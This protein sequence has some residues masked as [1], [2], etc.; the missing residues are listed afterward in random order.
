MLQPEVERL[1]DCT[2]AP[3]GNLIRFA[4]LTGLRQGELLALPDANVD[5]VS[6]KLS[7]DAT[8]YKGNLN[9]PKTV[10]G[11]RRVDLSAGALAVLKRQLLARKPNPNGF[12]FPSPEGQL[13]NADN[14]RH[15]VIG[16]AVKRAS[17]EGIKF[18]DLRH[19]YAALM[20]EAGA[21]PKYLQAQM[22]HTTIKTT[23]DTYGHL[24]LTQTEAS[25]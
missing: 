9:H 25:S 17:L 16:P 18:H 21:H 2:P 7:V 5:L 11:R 6:G 20:V 4:A 19:T 1:A 13:W 10:A 23:L 24:S 3:H 15:R 14:L 22:G 8:A 12:V